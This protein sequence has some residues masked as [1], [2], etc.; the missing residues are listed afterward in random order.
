MVFW[1]E[2]I[3][4]TKPLRAP[5]RALRRRNIGRTFPA[6]HLVNTTVA[7]TVTTKISTSSG[8]MVSIITK[9]ITTVTTL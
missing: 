2:S 3:S 9:D 6:S 4:S 8:A 1:P 7:G 5:S